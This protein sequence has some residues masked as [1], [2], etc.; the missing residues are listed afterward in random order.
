MAKGQVLARVI[1][2]SSPW[3]FVTSNRQFRMMAPWLAMPAATPAERW[4]GGYHA[5]EIKADLLAKAFE[6]LRIPPQNM[7]VFK[8]DLLALQQG[9]KDDNPFHGLGLMDPA[10]APDRAFFLGHSP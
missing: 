1:L 9:K 4:F 10:Y 5:R 3:D 6:A 2:F 7:R 8:G